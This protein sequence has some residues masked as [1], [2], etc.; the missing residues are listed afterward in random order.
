MNKQWQFNSLMSI[1]YESANAVL[2]RRNLEALPI[3]L[4][5]WKQKGTTGRQLE[6]LWCVS[7]YKS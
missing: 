5:L 3:G 2:S 1:I 6:V 7:L 4:S